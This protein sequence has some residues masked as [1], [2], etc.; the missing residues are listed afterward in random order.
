MQTFLPVPDFVRTAEILDMRRLGKQRVETKQ[1]LRAL[2]G[3]SK[4]WV[5]HPAVKMWRGHEYALTK[6]G[7]AMCLEWRKRGYKDTLLD[8]FMEQ[9]KIYVDNVEG[10]Y[11]PRWFGNQEFHISHQSNLIR[12][13]PFHYKPFFPGIPRDI[14]YVWP[15]P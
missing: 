7:L 5:N 10:N 2:T 15:V 14:P 6:Y 3:L 13:R 11:L 12:K 8:Y 4:G 1:I 9:R